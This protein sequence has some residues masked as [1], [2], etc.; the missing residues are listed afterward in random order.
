LFRL[1]VGLIA[2]LATCTAL[3]GTVTSASATSI[4]TLNGQPYTGVL[5]AGIHAGTNAVFT[6][7][8]GTITCNA[9][10]GTGAINNTGSLGSPVTGTLDAI[11]WKGNLGLSEACTD[12]IGGGGPPDHLD[13]TALGLPW[14]GDTDWVSNQTTGVFNAKDTYSGV[15]VNA[16]FAIPGDTLSCNFGGDFQNSGG[17]ANQI[18]GLL[19]NPDNTPSG[20]LELRLAGAHFDLL[21]SDAGCPSNGA[22]LTAVYILTGQGGVKLQ[23]REAPPLVPSVTPPAAAG[24]TGGPIAQAATP[25]KKCKKKKKSAKKKCRKRA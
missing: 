8:A 6:T 19:F 9:S 12:T 17:A 2:G 4:Q 10:N 20:H 16:T 3:A 13:F 25:H 18:Q 21:L 5:N 1:W 15:R 14:S 7:D 11:D 22:D 24:S 23:V